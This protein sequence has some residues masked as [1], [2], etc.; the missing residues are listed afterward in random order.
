MAIHASTKRSYSLKFHNLAYPCCR[1][2]RGFTKVCLCCRYS[3]ICGYSAA[4]RV[5]NSGGDG[6]LVARSSISRSCQL[7]WEV[8]TI[9]RTTTA[10]PGRKLHLGMHGIFCS[11]CYGSWY[12][13]TGPRARK[14]HYD[15]QST[16]HFEVWRMAQTHSVRTCRKPGKYK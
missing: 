1:Y 5:S 14:M 3:R 12:G 10:E 9:Y 6:I 7:P 15:F 4:G 13:D 2:S 8:C 16:M 11:L